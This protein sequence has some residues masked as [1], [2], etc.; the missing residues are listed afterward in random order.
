MSRSRSS[1]GIGASLYADRR[2][3]EGAADAAPRNRGSTAGTSP[4]HA[5]PR[6]RGSTAWTAAL[7][8][9]RVAAPHVSPCRLMTRR[10]RCLLFALA[11]LTLALAA[12]TL[13]GVHSD[14][15][16]AVPVLLFALPLLAGRYVGEERLA[17]L[18]AAFVT[19]R[20]RAAR[21]RCRRPRAARRV[22]V[23]RGGRLIAASLAVRPPPA[24]AAPHRRLARS[25]AFAD[26][27]F[28]PSRIRRRAASWPVAPLLPPRSPRLPRRS[29]PRRRS[30]T[31]ATRTTSRSSS[32][33]TP[34]IPGFSVV[35]LNGDDRLEVVNHSSK[36]ITIYGYNQEPYLRMASDG[37][38][39][40]NL[41]SPAYYLNNDP[42]GTAP[43]PASADAKAAPQ[44]KVVAT[45]GRYQFHDHRIHWMGAKNPPQVKDTSVR[46][47]VAPWRVPLQVDGTNGAIGGTL[48][49]RGSSGGPPAGAFIGLVLIL[50]VGAATVV[51]SGAGAASAA[52]T[53]SGSRKRRPGEM[54]RLALFAALLALLLTPA[55]ASAHAILESTS[56]TRGATLR[57][58]PKQVVLRFSETVEGNFGAVRVFD[59]K[60]QRVDDG[61]TVHPGGTGSQLAVGLKPGLPHGTYVATYRVISA[62]SHP[63]SG[64]L[65][66]SIGAPGAAAAP[67]VAVAHRRL[68]R[69][70][71]HRGRLRLRARPHVP[72]HRARPRRPRVP[73]RRLAAGAAV[74]AR[75]RG[76]SGRRRPRRSSP[77]RRRLLLGGAL[78][79]V[80]AGA[81][82]IVLQ[83]ATAG[84]TTV[85]AA[86]KPSVVSDVLGTR[87]GEVWSCALARVRHP[88]RRDRSPAARRPCRRR[89]PRACSASRSGP[90]VSRLP[91]CRAARSRSPRSPRRTSRSRPRSAATRASQ[92]PVALLFPLDVAHV[93]AMSVWIGGLAPAAVRPARGDAPSRGARSHAA[94]RREPHPL[95]ADR[96]GL[97]RRPARHRDD[98]GVRAHRG[99]GPAPAHGLRP[100]GADQGRPHPRADRG[101]R[102]EPPA[103]DPDAARAG[104]VRGCARRRRPSAAPHAARRGR[105][106]ARRARRD[107]GA[108]ELPAARLAR[109]RPVRRH[110]DARP[111]APRGDDGSRAG[112]PQRAAPLP[113]AAP[114]TARRS[115]ARRSSR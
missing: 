64:G 56:P 59:A 4:R 86:L 58:E 76:R 13:V 70:P 12:L 84:A 25:G 99:V 49:W 44:W 36:T 63:V 82:G 83:G 20:R 27:S 96:A 65:V 37:T 73:A 39:S 3:P 50:L 43:I 77:W 31:P 16:L 10:D 11:G 45:D 98:P 88:R 9:A 7:T 19:A 115:T 104:R 35:V 93:L 6:N 32:G 69:R 71:G 29:S 101:R 108:R 38:V 14:V 42:L 102:G 75:A 8:H 85:W 106:R 87:F 113:A 57:T 97:R 24:A 51:S 68:E 91:D 46:T 109:G 26:R 33:V 54:R 95:L 52:R 17:R 105:A 61:H 94:A 114:P 47:K 2:D 30:P 62:D 78:L 80:L 23:P 72:R 90:T 107:G 48:F 67:T 41:R 81:A 92:Q 15:L 60:A 5:A 110:G 1:A 55:V 53:G 79:G 74:G 111:A 22:A 100:R 28:S 66:F 18:A 89:R 34:S 103:R 40:V 21:A 112:R